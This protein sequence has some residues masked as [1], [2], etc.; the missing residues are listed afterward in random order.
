M[1]DLIISINTPNIWPNFALLVI[2]EEGDNYV[3]YWEKIT[4]NEYDLIG[5]ALPN[6]VRSSSATD[7]LPRRP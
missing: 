6:H 2:T 5:N 4:Y 7:V 1:R 3:L